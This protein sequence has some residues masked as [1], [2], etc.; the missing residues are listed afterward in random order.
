MAIK[1][2]RRQ[3]PRLLRMSE[4]RSD[5]AGATCWF[6]DDDMRTD[7]PPTGW[8]Y[9]DGIWRAG[10]APVGYAIAGSVVLE[11]HRHVLDQA[12][13][14]GEEAASLVGVT[15]RLVTAIKQAT[16]CDRV[17]QWATMDAFAHFHLWLVP[18][19]SSGELRG[20]RY[21]VASVGTDAAPTDPDV[22]HQT[23]EAIRAALT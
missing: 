15:G 6:C 21:L 12:D 9:D 22:V 10:H 8:L 1:R 16:G 4:T 5:T 3:S 7:L 14:T 19:S 11:A 23:A 17:Y 2:N 13:M 18:W 20:P